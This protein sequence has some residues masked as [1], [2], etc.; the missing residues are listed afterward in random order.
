MVSK[1]IY[2]LLKIPTVHGLLI[3][4]KH[5][6][7][8]A[9]IASLM[10]VMQISSY[11][12]NEMIFVIIV[13]IDTISTFQMI[14]YIRG[15]SEISRNG[16]QNSAVLTARLKQ[17]VSIMVYTVELKPPV[18][19][20]LLMVFNGI[21]TFLLRVFLCKLP[22]IYKLAVRILVLIALAAVRWVTSQVSSVE[23]PP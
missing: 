2:F 15:I 10:R 19:L 11:T 20:N 21:Q 6:Q 9:N 5:P 23:M 22:A 12:F 16:L 4:L 8:F 13:P 3:S 1:Y 17:S 18:W 7:L 14:A